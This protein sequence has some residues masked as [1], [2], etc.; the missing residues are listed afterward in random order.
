MIIDACT[1]LLYLS[2]LLEQRQ[3]FFRCLKTLLDKRKIRYNL[4]PCTKDI[5]AVDY[6]PIQVNENKFIQ[7]VYQPDYLQ[8]AKFSKTQ[9]DTT[10]VCEAIGLVTQKSDIK[11][12]GG[13]VIKGNSWVILTDKVFKENRIHSKTYIL[14]NLERLFDARIIIIPQQSYD[15]TGHADGIVRYYDDQTVLVNA[16]DAT[17]GNFLRRLKKTLRR[18]GLASIEIPFN[19]SFNSDYDMADGMYINFLQMTD[20]ILLPTFNLEDDEVAY[21]QFCELYPQSVVETI[22]SRGISIDGG[23]LNCISWNVKS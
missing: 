10:E 18:E 19:T 5:W 16:E 3:D 23:I 14:E 13:N 8:N 7:F 15:F 1:N 11:L 2:A 17:N 22:D 4:L 21:T 20:F 6:M 9:T 12:D